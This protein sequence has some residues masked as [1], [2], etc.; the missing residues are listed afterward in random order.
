MNTLKFLMGMAAGSVIGYSAMVLKDKKISFNV[1]VSDY[2]DDGLDEFGLE[3]CG[4]DCE[5]GNCLCEDDCEALNF[6]FVYEDDL[7]QEGEVF[8]ENGEPVNGPEEVTE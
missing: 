1:T 5:C 4:F 3:D 2:E 8:D 7:M 6:D